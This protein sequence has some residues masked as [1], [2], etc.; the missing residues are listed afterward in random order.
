VFK[1]ESNALRYFR[2]FK[3]RIQEISL[4]KFHVL[5]VLPMTMDI[6]IGG[7]FMTVN[8]RRYD[9]RLKNLVAES[10]DIERFRKFGIPD[11]SLRQWVKDGSREFLRYL[12]L[13]CV[14]LRSSKKICC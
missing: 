7:T 13:K 3:S 8:Y 12:N 14:R 2:G 1:L 4:S 6:V 9:P 10:G 11:S 5:R